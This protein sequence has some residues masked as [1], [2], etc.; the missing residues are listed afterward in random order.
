MA[1][2]ELESF[3]FSPNFLDLENELVVSLN[4]DGQKSLTPHSPQRG[5][6]GEQIV[7]PNPT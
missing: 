3:L 7:C 5:R 6:R 4:A 1:H 2:F